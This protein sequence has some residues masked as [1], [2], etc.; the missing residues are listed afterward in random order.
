MYAAIRSDAEAW[1]AP[2]SS[3]S[4][5][6]PDLPG[7]VFTLVAD[8]LALVGLWLALLA[9]VRGDQI[10]RR[11]LACSLV[12][13][14]M[15]ASRPSWPRIHPRSGSPCPCRALACAACGCTRRSDRT[16]K[17]GLL[18]GLRAHARFPTFLATY[19]PS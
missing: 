9:D 8:P 1:P 14:L 19:S 16:P 17:P 6:L 7:H 5:A 11:S 13:V 15:R 18:L 4:C 3:C 10:G 2:W 12:F